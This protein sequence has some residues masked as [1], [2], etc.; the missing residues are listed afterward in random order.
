[1]IRIETRILR[2]IRVAARLDCLQRLSNLKPTPDEFIIFLFFF[3]ILFFRGEIFT[4]LIHIH[5]CTLLKIITRLFHFIITE[6]SYFY[7]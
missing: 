7:Q 1:M 5:Q 2:V 6:L 4:E 3:F